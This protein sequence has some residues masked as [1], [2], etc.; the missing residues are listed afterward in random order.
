MILPES[1]KV[2]FSVYE[3]DLVEQALNRMLSKW[4]KSCVLRQF[5]SVLI[6][7]CQ[8]L[9]DACLDIQRLRTPYEAQGADLEALGRI[10]GAE[11][12]VWAYD[13]TVW[14]SFDIQGQ[15]FDQL[16]A[17]CIG[18]VTGNYVPAT[19]A[20][21][22]TNIILNAIKNMTLCASVPEITQFLEQVTDTPVS[23]QK[24]GPNAVEIIINANVSMATLRFLYRAFDTAR[25]DHVFNPPYPATMEVLGFITYVPGVNTDPNNPENSSQFMLF[26]KA[27]RYFDVSG[28]SVRNVIIPN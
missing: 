6:E 23:F 14:M 24:Q 28:W 3:K 26:D 11:R 2:D 15:S 12:G 10:V 19:D 21:Y 18:A 17:Y 5:V 7:Q 20:T 27:D 22:A 13:D 9:Y 8:E 25:A 16:P 4:L 1:F